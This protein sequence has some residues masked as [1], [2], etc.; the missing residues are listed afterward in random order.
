MLKG[1]IDIKVIFILI[2]AGLLIISLIF[3][4]SKKIDKRSVEIQNL[5]RQNDSLISVN[6]TL[7]LRNIKLDEEIS[8]ILIVIDSTQ[9]KLDETTKK[10][11]ELENGKTKINGYVNR[12]NADGIANTLSDYLN[13]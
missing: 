9:N 6:N 3:R 13:K 2:L 10:I 8:N 7:K 4:P 5:H 1:K 11:K 12:L